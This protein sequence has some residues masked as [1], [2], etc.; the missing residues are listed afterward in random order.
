MKRV[1]LLACAMVV[2]MAVAANAG[3]F[4][5]WEE[6]SANTVYHVSTDGLVV[7]GL[8]FNASDHGTGLKTGY[9]VGYTDSS[10]PPS[11]ARG[12]ASISQQWFNT[13]WIALVPYNSFTMPVRN[14]DYWKVEVGGTYGFYKIYF[15][16]AQ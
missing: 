9:I 12:A 15:L 14:G 10:N 8:G 2:Q 3:S 4:G 16:P 6:R 7:A 11:T 5:S 13:G 1:F